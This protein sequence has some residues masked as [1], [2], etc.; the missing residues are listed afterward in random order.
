MAA[1]ER[2]IL[3]KVDNSSV[4]PTTPAWTRTLS[5]RTCVGDGLPRSMKSTP[6]GVTSP[7]W[8]HLELLRRKSPGDRTGS[9]FCVCAM[10]PPN[11]SSHPAWVPSHGESRTEMCR[12]AFTPVARAGIRRRRHQ[13]PGHG[14]SPNLQNV[15]SS[16]PGPHCRGPSKL[17]AQHAARSSTH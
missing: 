12:R 14:I 13:L 16:E 6:F 2:M 17:S 9:S 7:H 3:T 10:W 5:E 11:A 4:Y 1:N 8:I 15:G